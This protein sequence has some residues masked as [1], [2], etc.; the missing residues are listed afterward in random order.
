MDYRRKKIATLRRFCSKTAKSKTGEGMEL[1]KDEFLNLYVVSI[2]EDGAVGGRKKQAIPARNPPAGKSPTQKKLKIQLEAR[3]TRATDIKR[4]DVYKGCRAQLS[5]PN[6]QSNSIKQ[7]KL[8]HKYQF[9]G[10]VG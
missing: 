3:L 1:F 6:K 7:T 4:F 2:E 5:N 10:T 8:Q 9:V